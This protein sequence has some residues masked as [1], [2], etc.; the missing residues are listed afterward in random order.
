[1][2]EN[3]SE[4]AF[5]SLFAELR[6]S[7]GLCGL[8]SRCNI[9]KGADKDKCDKLVVA[10]TCTDEKV[11]VFVELKGSDVAHAVKQLDATLSYPLFSQNRAKWTKARIVANKI[12]ANTGRSVVERA[13]VDF[14][15]KY[16]CELICL[17]SGQ[18]DFLR[19][20]KLK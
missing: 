20:E 13:K 14:R 18:P 1:M 9:I 4:G 7:D 17:K 6:S 3:Q 5:D 12:P 16:N 8:S 2:F 19:Q 10:T 11:C 15:R